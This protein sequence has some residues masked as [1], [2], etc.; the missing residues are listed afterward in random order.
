MKSATHYGNGKE[1]NEFGI[2]KVEKEIN[3]VHSPLG[4]A[5]RR[6]LPSTSWMKDQATEFYR[7]HGRYPTRL[8]LEGRPGVTK[9]A[10][11]YLDRPGLPAACVSLAVSY[12][13]EEDS[14]A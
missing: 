12:G 14:L 1:T 4:L 9:H 10:A 3:F 5:G 7:L 8:R 13:A 2:P 6:D 11:F